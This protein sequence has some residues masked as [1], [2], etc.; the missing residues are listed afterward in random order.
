MAAGVTNL[1][2]KL[3][4]ETT[5]APSGCKSCVDSSG[6]HL[7][8]ITEPTTGPEWT[9]S[10]DHDL[11]RQRKAAKSWPQACSD[12]K[13][14]HK[15]DQRKPAESPS[16]FTSSFLSSSGLTCECTAVQSRWTTLFVGEEA[17]LHIIYKLPLAFSFAG[18]MSQPEENSVPTILFV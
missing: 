6:T 11:T 9:L 18:I 10:P 15:H 14:K 16:S 5:S 17:L 8:V 7:R 3:L 2:Q 4:C 12:V 13:G 1:D